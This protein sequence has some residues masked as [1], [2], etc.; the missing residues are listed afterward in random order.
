M[1]RRKICLFRWSIKLSRKLL[2][3]LKVLF[4]CNIFVECIFIYILVVWLARIFLGSEWR[5]LKFCCEFHLISDNTFNKILTS[6]WNIDLYESADVTFALNQNDNLQII[7]LIIIILTYWNSQT[8]YTT[9]CQPST[10]WMDY[11][12]SRYLLQRNT[13]NSVSIS[14]IY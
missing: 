4:N 2:L 13:R 6:L 5:K 8:E 1:W 7:M 9:H 11:S 12:V 10:A 14:L 3:T